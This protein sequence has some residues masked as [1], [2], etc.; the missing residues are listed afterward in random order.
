MLVA[1]P[2]D[3]GV[4]EDGLK[5]QVTPDGSPVHD[6]PTA[7]TKALRLAT[8]TVPVPLAPWAMVSDDGAAET[9]KSGG[10]GAVLTA[11]T[12]SSWSS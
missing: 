12:R 9:E 4:T 6:R 10:G 7:E 11:K 1:L 3:G 5:P 8:V 2:P